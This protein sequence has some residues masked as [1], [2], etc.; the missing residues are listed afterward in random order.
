MRQRR[1]VVR[2]ARSARRARAA[3]RGRAV[4]SAP[5]VRVRTVRPAGTPPPEVG[6]A[7]GR[8]RWVGRAACDPASPGPVT[9]VAEYR[10]SV[11]VRRRGQHRSR[12]RA[13]VGERAA[14][15]AARV[16]EVGNGPVGGAARARPVPEEAR[17]AREAGAVVRTGV[18]PGAVEARRYGWGRASVVPRA[19]VRSRGSDLSLPVRACGAE[20]LEDGDGR[21]RGGR[22]LTAA[23]GFGVVRAA[24]DRAWRDPEVRGPPVVERRAG[25]CREVVPATGNAGEAAVVVEVARVPPR[26]GPAAGGARWAEAWTKAWAGRGRRR[27]RAGTYGEMPKACRGPARPPS[28]AASTDAPSHSPRTI[29]GRRRVGRASRRR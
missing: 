14:V 24:R 8:C 23:A 20:G 26:A 4:R 18:S 25:S 21:C 7:D 22:H 28:C 12:P 2:Q 9:V 15:A 19:A 11:P 5:G 3:P 29:G 1:A 27:P 6:D 16:G 10:R 13:S 17:E